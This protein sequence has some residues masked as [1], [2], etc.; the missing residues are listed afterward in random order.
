MTSLTIQ[1]PDDTA[2]RLEGLATSQRKTLQEVAIDSM[3]SFADHVAAPEHSTAAAILRG[4]RGLPHV[5]NEDVDALE[6]AIKSGRVP[7]QDPDIFRE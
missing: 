7:P 4:L 5:P 2:R 6:A 3:N 1:I